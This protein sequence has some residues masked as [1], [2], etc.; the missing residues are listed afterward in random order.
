MAS[1]DNYHS[2]GDDGDGVCD[3]VVGCFGDCGSG[4]SRVRY[5]SGAGGGDNVIGDSDKF[6]DINN[7]VKKFPSV[8]FVIDFFNS[9]T[10]GHF[11]SQGIIVMNPVIFQR[12]MSNVRIIPLAPQVTETPLRGVIHFNHDFQAEFFSGIH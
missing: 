9:L 8:S 7:N 1:D 10:K 11:M 4:C 2:G 5:C 3:F 6:A 12:L